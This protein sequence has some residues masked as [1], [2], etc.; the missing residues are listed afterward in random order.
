[1]AFPTVRARYTSCCTSR[2]FLVTAL[3]LSAYREDGGPGVFFRRPH[4]YIPSWRL[5]GLASSAVTEV[6]ASATMPGAALGM[7]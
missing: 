2:S 6:T 5:V 1:M 4:L 3:P 7:Y